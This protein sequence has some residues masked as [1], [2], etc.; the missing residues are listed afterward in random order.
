[1]KK[2][3]ILVVVMFAVSAASLFAEQGANHNLD[4]YNPEYVTGEILIKFTDNTEIMVTDKDSE[5]SVGIDIR[6]K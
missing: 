5:I 1:M 6:K 2:M 4:P 3:T